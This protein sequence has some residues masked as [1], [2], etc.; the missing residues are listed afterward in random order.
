MIRV[1]LLLLSFFYTYATFANTTIE[2]HF[3]KIK[4]NPAQLYAFLKAMPKG[5]ELHY[6]FSGS[7]HPEWMLGLA[8]TQAFC[9]DKKKWALTPKQKQCAGLP[10]TA[11][12]QHEHWYKKILNAW[13]FHHFHPGAE[14]AHDHF[15]SAFSKFYAVYLQNRGALLALMM[16]HAVDQHEQYLEIMFL[17]TPVPVWEHP[18]ARFSMTQLATYH[19]QLMHSPAFLKSVTQSMAEMNAIQRAARHT[20]HCDKNPALPACQI[21]VAF[22]YNAKRDQPLDKIFPQLLQGF[23]LAQQRSSVVGVNFMQP[24]D[25]PTPLRDYHQHMQLFDYLH[26]QY[27]N[28]HIALHAGELTQKVALNSSRDHIRQA[29]LLGHAERIGHG[30]DIRFEKKPEDLVA[31]LS[32]KRV[33]VEVCLTSNQRILQMNAAQHPLTY[34]L[35]HHVPVVLSTDDEGVLRTTLTREYLLATQRYALNYPT[36]KQISRNSLTYA[37]LPGESIWANARTAELKAPCVQLTDATCLR[38]IASSKKATLQWRLE[39]AFVAFEAG[40]LAQ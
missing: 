6:H 31:Y 21:E 23:L 17:P 11:L 33:A 4:Q 8:A 35:K 13:S 7:A 19:Q 36:L 34:F 3:E 10:S 37:F 30:V 5:G 40:E 9:L 38:W 22:L 29:V 1:T 20:L 24:E 26:Q 39:R 2:A 32:N 16:Q 12:A 25:A 28:V 18:P 27:P 14:S 15:F